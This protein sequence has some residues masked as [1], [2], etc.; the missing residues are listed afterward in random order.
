MKPLLD[1][2]FQGVTS[3]QIWWVPTAVLLIFVSRGVASYIVGYT[4]QWIANNVLRDLR[5]DMFQKLLCLPVTFFDRSTAG[6]LI[7]KLLVEAQM[8]LLVATNVITVI[9]RDTLILLGLIGWLFWL[10]WKLTLVVAVL[11]PLLAV[12]SMHF[13]KRMRDI[14]GK[15]MSASGDMTATIGECIAANR[16]IKIFGG[17]AHEAKRFDVINARYRGQAMRLAIAQSLQ[18]PLTQLIAAVGVAV[19]LTIA[20]VQ[21]RA[22]AATVGDFVSF[23]TAMLMM[24]GPLRHLTDVNSQIQR[25][26]VAAE[27][28]LSFIDEQ[29]EVDLGQQAIARSQG[30]IYFR[31]VSITYPGRDRPAVDGITLRIAAGTTV[32][33]VGPSGSGKTSLISLLPRFYE[34]TSGEILL[35]GISI[36]RFSLRNLRTQI[37]LVSQDVI[38]FNDSILNNITYGSTDLAEDT[39][40]NAI[41]SAD[42]EDFIRSL[43]EGLNTVVGDRGVKLSGGQRQ[44]VAI[45]RAFVKDAPIL[46]LD[47]ATSALD[48]VSETSIRSAVDNLR[49][50]RTTL[51]VAHRL[52]TVV[53]ADQIVVM[54]HGRV[55]QQG[56]HKDLLIEAGL[57]RDLYARLDDQALNALPEQ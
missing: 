35:D 53:D 52:S 14:S 49:R 33:F 26:L 56:T 6:H 4:M 42:L 57:Y 17:E 1:K 39:L 55:I 37:A 22:G 16:V 21:S 44:R 3:F 8:V 51:I 54:E 28:V 29:N 32:A 25:G 23:I 40:W 24:F 5:R 10:N 2:G 43:P 7:A 50:G 27:S 36:D 31:D 12:L 19:V 18:S 11:M 13:S 47:E 15:F 34:K 38:L 45:A 46:I 48:N 9:V 30:E 41:R 20:L